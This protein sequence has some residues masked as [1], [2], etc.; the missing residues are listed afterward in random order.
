[1]TDSL[2]EF[3]RTGRLGDITLGMSPIELQAHWGKPNDI[4]VDG[5]IWQYGSSEGVNIQLPIIDN[6][7]AGIWI[8]FWAGTDT[9]AIPSGILAGDWG[10][11]ALASV[12]EFT[13]FLDAN[14]LEWS[15]YEPLTFDDQSCIALRS[16]VQCSW[17]H[18]PGPELEKI[19]ITEA[20]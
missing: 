19:M 11:H 6:R 1:M 14:G 9:D 5:R 8:Y 16:N 3:M 4:S 18:D 17:S 15:H 7:V 20:A 12:A 10:V 13:D 2:L